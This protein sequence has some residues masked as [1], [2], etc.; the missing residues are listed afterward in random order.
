MI[1]FKMEEGW[2]MKNGGSSTKIFQGFQKKKIAAKIFLFF[3]FFL[4][5]NWPVV[6]L[7]SLNWTYENLH[8]YRFLV[9]SNIDSLCFNKDWN[10][11]MNVVTTLIL[12]WSL[13]AKNFRLM[14]FKERKERD[15]GLLKNLAIINSSFF[16][17]LLLCFLNELL[18]S[19][20]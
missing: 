20:N 7:V 2:S 12:I 10:R 15:E 14:N 16:F 9:K 18:E 17:P 1:H 6:H 4:F 8:L 11:K 3:S 13:S 5:K 19:L